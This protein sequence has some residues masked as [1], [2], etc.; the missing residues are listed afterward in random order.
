MADTLS[1]D[2]AWQADRSHQLDTIMLAPTR[3]LVSQLNQ[4]A[5]DHRLTGQQL[6]PTVRLADGNQA[7]VGE[8]IITCTNDRT[9]RLPAT[10]RVKN[11]DRWTV[12]HVHDCGDLTVQHR[13]NQLTVRLPTEYLQASAKLGYATTVTPPKACRSTPCMAS[14]ADRS[15]GNSCTQ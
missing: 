11:R 15:H 6:G 3:D 4:R 7:S 9:L 10:D 2:T 14:P 1:L 12:T 5:R 8:L 13:H